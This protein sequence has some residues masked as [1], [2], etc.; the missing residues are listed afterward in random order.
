M[1]FH[2]YIAANETS[3]Y[4]STL[5]AANSAPQCLGANAS[6][7][8]ECP[9]SGIRYWMQKDDL[10]VYN[11]D[12]I[13]QIN[14]SIEEITSIGSTFLRYMVGQTSEVY[15]VDQSVYSTSILSKYLGSALLAYKY[16]LATLGAD[17]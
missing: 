4:P 5:T 1:N 9:S 6:L 14:Q 7:L 3:L 10:F 16:V 11:S 2:V 8:G 13:N 15:Q 12:Q 17:P